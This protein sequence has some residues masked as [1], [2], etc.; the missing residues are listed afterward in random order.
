MHLHDLRLEYWNRTLGN[1]CGV[2]RFERQTICILKL[3]EST[4]VTPVLNEHSPCAASI[5]GT[6][7]YLKSRNKLFSE[8]KISQTTYHDILILAA[9]IT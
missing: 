4:K 5:M 3:Q 8:Y 6:S 2:V 9:A 7:I 1:F